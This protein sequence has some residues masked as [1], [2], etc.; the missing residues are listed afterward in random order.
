[1]ATKNYR[2]LLTAPYKTNENDG[3]RSDATKFVLQNLS[4]I[5]PGVIDMSISGSGTS[6]LIFTKT[7][8]PIMYGSYFNLS[9]DPN[10]QFTIN[11]NEQF[12]F[13]IKF[14]SLSSGIPTASS[15][16]VLTIV[17]PKITYNFSISSLISNI[18]LSASASLSAVN[19]NGRF[20]RSD[21]NTLSYLPSVFFKSTL[22]SVSSATDASIL[23]FPDRYYSGGRWYSYSRRGIG[24]KHTGTNG[25][26]NI[27]GVMAS[28]ANIP[29][30]F[31]T[32]HSSDSKMT[33][34]SGLAFSVNL[35]PGETTYIE[36]QMGAP[37]QPTYYQD[38]NF[39]QPATLTL[40]HNADNIQSPIVLNLKNG[41][42]GTS[43]GDF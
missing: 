5:A 34:N 33:I 43:Y 9:A 26:L 15:T 24:F 27:Q 30:N 22:T 19:S 10:Y 41:L 4:D 1:M 35:K 36:L 14:Q 17:S 11:P 31:V 6:N 18:I 39:S 32:I 8:Q 2:V 42:S 29:V 13:G 16:A 3:S 38:S 12:D 7:D 20:D 23:V 25:V 40:I 28:P 21:Q 37:N